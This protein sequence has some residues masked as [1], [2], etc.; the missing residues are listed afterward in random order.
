M[1]PQ[2]LFRCE[3]VGRQRDFE[4]FDIFLNDLSLFST[5]F[6]LF[7]PKNSIGLKK[8]WSHVRKCQIFAKSFCRPMFSQRNKTWE[9]ISLCNETFHKGCRWKELSCSM[10]NQSFLAF[11]IKFFSLFF[12]SAQQRPI[13]PNRCECLKKFPN[14]SM[15]SVSS[16]GKCLPYVSQGW[17]QKSS[18]P[19]LIMTWTNVTIGT[20]WW[21]AKALPL[22]I[23]RMKMISKLSQEL[24][25]VRSK[26]VKASKAW[27][28]N[29]TIWNLRL[30]TPP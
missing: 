5:Q 2:V 9:N 30:I 12:R 8:D 20:A 22:V 25:V 21:V 16:R 15:L 23:P 11:N 18:T 17:V 13:T 24:W 26:W 19:C 29:K 10:F 3:N 1:F 28:C 7:R 6:T 14:P 4:I 27:P